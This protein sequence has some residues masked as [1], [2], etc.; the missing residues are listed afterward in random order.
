M[1]IL[2]SSV[3]NLFR[4]KEQ[5]MITAINGEKADRKTLKRSDDEQQHVGI[6]RALWH[7]HDMIITDKAIDLNSGSLT[8]RKRG[9]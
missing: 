1:H 2:K 8:H 3:K 7:N 5:N 9:A 6:A 4:N